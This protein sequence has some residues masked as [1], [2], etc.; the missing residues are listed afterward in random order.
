MTE[1]YI[2]HYTSS[3]SEN[4]DGIESWNMSAKKAKWEFFKQNTAGG[5]DSIGD[6]TVDGA[7][8]EIS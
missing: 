6:V 5:L 2:T 4:Q 8:G 3:R 1:V 7:S